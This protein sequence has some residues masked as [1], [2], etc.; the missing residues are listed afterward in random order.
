MSLR[1]I[2]KVLI[3]FLLF[4]SFILMNFAS[5]DE[6]NYIYDDAGRLVKAVKGTEGFIYSYDEVGNLLSISSST[7]S[8]VLPVLQDISPD[9]F[10]SGSTASVTITG[11]NLFTTK[12]VS[13]DNPSLSIKI[14][15]ITDTEIS[16]EIEVSTEAFLGGV[17]I[18]VA[19]LYGSASIPIDILKLTLS[20]CTAHLLAGETEEITVSLIPA[21]S[22]N[23]N[24]VNNNPD[25]IAAPQS[26][27]IPVS[28]TASFTVQALAVGTGI[29]E[30]EKFLS[31]IF[32]TPSFTGYASIS[33]PSVSVS[34]GLIQNA[35][36]ESKPV[37]VM[38]PSVNNA[39]V[40]S[41]PVSI[42]ISD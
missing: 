29:L 7:I 28:G 37:S 26:I 16:A 23:L 6:V 12:E 38:W 24:I 21:R 11:Q 42:E 30:I 18:T 34:W 41:R 31:T 8:A 25:I 36:M 13:S 4:I 10:F 35:F 20:P 22:M 39:I 5:A 3:L 15:H 32:V 1:Q 27:Q 9:I 14:L 19:T 33:S 17:N 2:P 40:E